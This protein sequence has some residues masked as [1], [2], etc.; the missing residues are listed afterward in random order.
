M[1]K[2]LIQLCLLQLILSQ[3]T[4]TLKDTPDIKVPV[5]STW[6]SES[7]PGSEISKSVDG[8]PDTNYHSRWNGLTSFPVILRYNFDN[9]DHIDYLIV[10]PRLAGTNGLFGQFELWVT[11]S[12][13][14]SYKYGDYDFKK[15]SK[16]Q[17]LFFNPG[18]SSPKII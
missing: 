11:T 5:T 4:Q 12:T 15:E 16:T 7:Q 8:K 18:L 1:I 2:V 9:V 6:A 14:E 10:V 3:T 13:Q 17:T